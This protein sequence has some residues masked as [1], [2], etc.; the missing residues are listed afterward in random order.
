[1][2]LTPNI[3]PN[4]RPDD[5]AGL[6]AA[7]GK[8]VGLTSSAAT[9]TPAVASAPTVSSA[10]LA[11]ALTMPQA[12]MPVSMQQHIPMV[13]QMNTTTFV[14]IQPHHNSFSGMMTTNG[15]QQFLWQPVP[16]GQVMQTP[17]NQLQQQQIPHMIPSRAENTLKS[18]RTSLSSKTSVQRG[19]GNNWTLLI[20][21]LIIGIIVCAVIAW[22]RLMSMNNTSSRSQPQEHSL[23]KEKESETDVKEDDSAS[24]SSESSENENSRNHYEEEE[25]IKELPPPSIVN[26]GKKNKKEIPSLFKEPFEVEKNLLKYVHLNDSEDDDEDFEKE[27]EEENEWWIPKQHHQHPQRPNKKKQD[28]FIDISGEDLPE[29]DARAAVKESAALNTQRKKLVADE[30]EE[31]LEYAKKRD[32]LFK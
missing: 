18:S 12:V 31:V 8:G 9:A 27:E 32:S 30:S 6:L 29:V 14:P 17:N 15:N 28:A 2:E 21:V 13:P 16:L 24:T 7:L 19:Q 23:K 10:P 1:M 26:S 22:M 25:E 11:A 4:I 5:F 3:Q 20:G